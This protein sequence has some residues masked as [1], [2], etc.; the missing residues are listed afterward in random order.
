MNS[1]IT[2]VTIKSITTVLLTAFL[3]I[4]C[5]SSPPEPTREPYNDADSQRSRSDQAQR[6]MSKETR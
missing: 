2:T 3:V 6:E 5:A 1:M 4:G